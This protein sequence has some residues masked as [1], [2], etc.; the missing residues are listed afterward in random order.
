MI[1]Q[2]DILKVSSANLIMY[3]GINKFAEASLFFVQW[4]NPLCW[5]STRTMPGI[6]LKGPSQAIKENGCKN[7]HV[8]TKPSNEPKRRVV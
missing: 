3:S 7:P 2:I 1:G 8:Q 5:E 4:V 6:F